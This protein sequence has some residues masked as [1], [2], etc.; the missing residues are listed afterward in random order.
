MYSA[1]QGVNRAPLGVG[2]GQGVPYPNQPPY[3]T[4]DDVAGQQPQDV[5]SSAPH[6]APHPLFNAYAVT[7]GAGDNVRAP[8]DHPDQSSG[9]GAIDD[10]FP[11][12][13]EA[14]SRY[15]MG[16]DIAG[17]QFTYPRSWTEG[18]AN[19]VNQIIG[20]WMQ[21][22]ALREQRDAKERKQ[23]SLIAA[24]QGD[25]SDLIDRLINS[26]DPDLVQMG[27]DAKIKQFERQ[28]QQAEWQT[29]LQDEKGNPIAQQNTQTGEVKYLRPSTSDYAA[30]VAAATAA[31]RAAVGPSDDQLVSDEDAKLYG[32]QLARGDTS[33]LTNWGRGRQ[34]PNNLRKIRH[35]AAEWLR[36]QYGDDAGAQAAANRG[37]FQGYTSGQ[38]SLGTQAGRMGAASEEARAMY[39]QA[40]EASQN[41]PRGKFRTWNQALRWYRSQVNDPGAARLNAAIDSVVNTRA[42]ALNPT[43]QNTDA[44]RREGLG[45]LDAAQSPEA[46]AATLDQFEKETEAARN[47]PGTAGERL[48]NRFTGRNTPQ[49]PQDQAATPPPPA[50]T[51][52][53]KYDWDKN[54]NLVRVQ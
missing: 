41:I 2:Y 9:G 44:A 34:G 49:Q 52:P 3:L 17:H 27:V 37:D 45:L 38:R 46:F 51:A 19:G 20:T 14:A 43:G 40:R 28:H 21:N 13:E 11:T 23:K 42:R 22:R 4:F 30:Q 50:S 53:A 12:E 54:G 26:N 7:Q 36:Q 31:A 18:L 10:N 24:V 8:N 1:Y 35:Y 33:V 6:G 29:I 32:E 16:Q 47:A 48:R 15:R 5:A 25:G 39:Q